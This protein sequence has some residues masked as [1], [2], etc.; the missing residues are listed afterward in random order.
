MH[1]AAVAHGAP[2]L[3]CTQMLP[4][5]LKPVTQSELAAQLVLHVVAPQM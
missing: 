2:L 3:F 1:S 5:Q 4:T